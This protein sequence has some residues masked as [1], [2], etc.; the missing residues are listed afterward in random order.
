VLGRP[1]VGGKVGLETLHLAANL[2]LDAVA[3]CGRGCWRCRDCGP[4]VLTLDPVG[5]GLV[6]SLAR[7]GGNVTGRL[8][9]A[10]ARGGFNE[11]TIDLP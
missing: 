1:R 5:G 7:P 8:S 9:S 6:A 2:R 4:F 11:F 10:K 3:A